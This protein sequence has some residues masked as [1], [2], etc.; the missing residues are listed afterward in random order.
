MQIQGRIDVCTWG[1]K[2]DALHKIGI[3]FETCLTAANKL[4]P[5]AE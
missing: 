2:S 3:L 1:G 4:S 5:E